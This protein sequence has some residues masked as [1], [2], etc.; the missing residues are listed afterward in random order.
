MVN[1]EILKR[2]GR[3]RK[4]EERRMRGENWG[5]RCRDKPFLPNMCLLK[6]NG[7][8]LGAQIK[9]V[10]ISEDQEG[11]QDGGTAHDGGRRG[12]MGAK[13]PKESQTRV[14]RDGMNGGAV[15]GCWFLC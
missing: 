6:A 4:R 14:V 10:G 3:E 15:T 1:G 12:Q 2:K 11:N 7:Q 13:G 5:W 9:A 8:K